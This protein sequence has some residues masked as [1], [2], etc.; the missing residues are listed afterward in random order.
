MVTSCW[1]PLLLGQWDQVLSQRVCRRVFEV[2]ETRLLL[3]VTWTGWRDGLAGT[4]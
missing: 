4:S 1:V 2:L 3:G